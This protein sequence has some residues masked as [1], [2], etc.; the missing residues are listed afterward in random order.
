MNSYVATNIT[1]LDRIPMKLT[2]F[3]L[4]EKAEGGAGHQF[5]NRE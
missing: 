1:S 5:I 4:L 2:E 3:M